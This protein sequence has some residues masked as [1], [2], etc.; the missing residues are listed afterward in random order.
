MDVV[1][2]L[3]AD[4]LPRQGCISIPGAVKGC[5][6]LGVLNGQQT[7]LLGRDERSGV[8]AFGRGRCFSKTPL[9]GFIQRQGGLFDSYL[10]TRSRFTHLGPR[11]G[12]KRFYQLRRSLVTIVGVLG[13]PLEHAGLH[14]RGKPWVQFP[15]LRSGLMD[16]GHQGLGGRFT[17]RTEFGRRA[18]DMQ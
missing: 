11:A 8:R 10:F 6:L 1:S 18:S 5:V 12:A 7:G 13:D 2:V 16:V 15:R 17:R 9:S 14:A 3:L 4:H